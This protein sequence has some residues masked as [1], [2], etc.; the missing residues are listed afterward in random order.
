MAA[1]IESLIIIDFEGTCDAR[2][3][4]F[5][6]ISSAFLALG[7]FYR[8]FSAQTLPKM[9]AAALTGGMLRNLNPAAPTLYECD[10][11]GGDEEPGEVEGDGNDVSAVWLTDAA[12]GAGPGPP[13]SN[14]PHA[15]PEKLWLPEYL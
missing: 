15:A 2:A 4:H 14:L 12:C 7:W 5:H 9:H 13:P 11:D 3:F 10:E 1:Q 6:H 8:K